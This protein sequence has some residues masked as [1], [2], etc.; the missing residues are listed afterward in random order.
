MSSLGE[1]H[2]G[3]CRLDFPILKL[4]IVGGRPFSCGGDKIFR[5]RLLSERLVGL[6][7]IR[8]SIPGISMSRKI[9]CLFILIS[10]NEIL[11]GLHYFTYC[12]IISDVEFGNPDTSGH[13]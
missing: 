4:S 5:G 3:Y 7:F 11:R 10:I 12:G 8:M 9:C 6:K 2:V 13:S 1:E